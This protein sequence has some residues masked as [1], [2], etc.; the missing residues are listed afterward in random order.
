MFAHSQL[1]IFLLGEALKT[2]N[3]ILNRVPSKT[4]K[5][6]PFECW[7]GRR[8]S[9]NHFHLWGCKA[10]ARF[11]NPSEKKLD[12]RTIS[13]RSWD[14]QRSQKVTGFIVLILVEESWKPIMPSS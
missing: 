11:Y 3:Y 12:P 5:L 9:F 7:T 2:A 6:V 8:L 13:C 1:P 4:V 10:E 14:T